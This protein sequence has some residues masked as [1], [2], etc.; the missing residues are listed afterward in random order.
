MLVDTSPDMREQLLDAR[1]GRLDGVL[2]THD[3]ADQLHGMDDLRVITLNAHKRADVWADKTAWISRDDRSSA[4]ALSSRKGSDYPPILNAHEIPEPF[5]PF[6]ISGPG[7]AVP[8][9]AFGQGHG[10]IRSL[11]FRFG[12]VA[13]SSDVDE[14]DEASLRGA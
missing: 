3:H 11:G 8:V 12:P 7:G 14:L 6:A 13:Y 9:L 10:R 4:I 1:I 2:I 5:A